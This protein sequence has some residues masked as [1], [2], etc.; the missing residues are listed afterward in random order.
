MLRRCGWL[1]G[2]PTCSPALAGPSPRETCVHPT[3]PP[4]PTVLLLQVLFGT[5]LLLFLAL[6]F[7]L[8]FVTLLAPALH[9]FL[10]KTE[11]AEN[12][13]GVVDPDK[14]LLSG[15]QTAVFLPSEEVF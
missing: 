13:S 15:R 12:F 7:S 6:G 1:T 4:A 11:M 5:T 2:P 8:D 9:L 14:G 3:A 10:S